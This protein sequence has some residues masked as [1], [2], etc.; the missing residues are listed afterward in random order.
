MAEEEKAASEPAQSAVPKMAHKP[1]KPVMGGLTQTKTDKWIAWTGGNPKADWSGFVD[2]NLVDFETPH[3]MRPV[4]DVK[5][6]NHCK[7]GF[8]QPSSTS[9]TCLFPS[10]SA[11]GPT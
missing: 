11:C 6:Y 2:K 4:Y 7:T 1:N 9:L 5:G 8:C 10:R 3:Q